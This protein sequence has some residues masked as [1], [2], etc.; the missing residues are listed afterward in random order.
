MRKKLSLSMGI[1]ILLYFSPPSI[2]LWLNPSP[3]TLS[4]MFYLQS[5]LSF[6]HLCLHHVPHFWCVLKTWTTTH[7][8]LLY[9]PKPPSTPTTQ[10]H[11]H[12]LHF[13]HFYYI[14][15]YNLHSKKHARAETIEKRRRRNATRILIPF[16]ITCHF[17]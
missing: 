1:S 8:P 11:F 12:Q 15:Y 4:C 9:H 3:S 2:G 7:P 6:P 17:F 13:N 14:P 16:L 10:P 5:H